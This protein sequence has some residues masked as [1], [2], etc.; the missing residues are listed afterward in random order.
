ME[1]LNLPD[2]AR[3]FQG[4][5]GLVIVADDPVAPAKVL[6]DFAKEHD[7]KPAIKAGIVERRAVDAADVQRLA[8]LPGRPELLAQLAGAME[9]PMAQ[10]ASALQAKIN[11]MAGLIDALRESREA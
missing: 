5:T 9:A 3:F 1:G 10:F 2:V 7:Q 4:P 6:Y 8:S 11:E